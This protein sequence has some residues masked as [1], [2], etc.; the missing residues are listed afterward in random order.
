MT[1]NSESVF[2]YFRVR[3][4]PSI[5]KGIETSPPGWIDLKTWQK[6]KAAKEVMSSFQSVLAIRFA[7]SRLFEKTHGFFDVD[8]DGGV[9]VKL[10]NL[11]IMLE[12]MPPCFSNAENDLSQDA[13]HD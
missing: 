11:G 1:L 2:K 4:D 13:I 6:R 10:E 8:I 12:K 3:F 7:C 9:S 5:K